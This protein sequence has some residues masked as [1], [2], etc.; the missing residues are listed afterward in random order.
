MIEVQPQTGEPCKQ[1]QK[2]QRKTAPP[3]SLS[4]QFPVSTGASYANVW[5]EAVQFIL[6]G[7]GG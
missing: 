7:G 6:L 2:H 1:W 5:E 4:L 3:L